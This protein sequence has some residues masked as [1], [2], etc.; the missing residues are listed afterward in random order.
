[1]WPDDCCI[2]SGDTGKGKCG[3]AI[4]AS[5]CISPGAGNVARQLLHQDPPVRY[6]STAKDRETA[7]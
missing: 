3:P 4:V 5:S 7:S 1:M 2:K 6:K